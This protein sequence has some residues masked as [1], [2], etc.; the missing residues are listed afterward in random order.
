[1]RWPS[2]WQSPSPLH[3]LSNIHINCLLIEDPFVP[4]S[5]IEEAQGNCMYVIHGRSEL[6][7][8]TVID[9]VR[10]GAVLSQTSGRVTAPSD[11]AGLP[12]ADSNDGKSVRRL[13][14]IQFDHVGRCNSGGPHFTAVSAVPKLEMQ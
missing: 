14:S 5:V 3:Q 9:G 6:P 7:G 4:L 1:M 11:P 2:Q 12:W 10:P 8:F 13:R